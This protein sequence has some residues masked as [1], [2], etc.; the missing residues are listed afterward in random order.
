MSIRVANPLMA[1]PKLMDAIYPYVY[2]GYE[3][4][5][6]INTLRLKLVIS[7]GRT[8]TIGDIT[9]EETLSYTKEITYN[10]IPL[11]P[12]CYDYNTDLTPEIGVFEL[13]AGTDDTPLLAANEF[14]AITY[15]GDELTLLQTAWQPLALLVYNDAEFTSA[16]VCG[17]W[18]YTDAGNPDNN[19][20]GDLFIYELPVPLI[21]QSYDRHQPAQEWNGNLNNRDLAPSFFTSPLTDPLNIDISAWTPT[22]WRSKLGLRTFSIDEPSPWRTSGTS[23]VNAAFEWEIT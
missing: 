18:T 21:P 8:E 5:P 4:S 20:S 17:G 3:A 15:G 12:S 16:E 10:R 2:R 23:T 11:P 6:I 1:S 13:G 14:R 22:D 9:R 19:D 7:G